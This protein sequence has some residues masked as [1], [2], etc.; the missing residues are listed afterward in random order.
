MYGTC[1]LDLQEDKINIGI[2]NIKGLKKIISSY[3]DFLDILPIWIHSYDKTR[4]LRNINREKNPNY[5]EICRR[6]LSD[7]AD[8]SFT[9]ML[10]ENDW[11]NIKK[12]FQNIDVFDFEFYLNEKNEDYSGILNRPKLKTFINEGQD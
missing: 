10:G 8:F 9:F 3:S 6:F 1:I 7:Y 4:L 11:T 2:F 12:I 5:K